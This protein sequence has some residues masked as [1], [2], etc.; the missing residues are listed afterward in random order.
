ME[1]SNAVGALGALAQESRLRIFRLLIQ[2]G[3]E[4]MA[5]G[6]IARKLK[7]PP[8][9]LSFHVAILARAGLVA[10]RKE[11]RSVV[12][13]LDLGGTRALLG[14]LVDDCCRG[15]PELCGA[16]MRSA[17]LQPCPSA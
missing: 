10:A 8:N 1:I 6:D 12:Y 14:F 15:Q 13:S 11:G 4:G 9:T 2:R 3:P 7:L 17:R 5:A 16:L